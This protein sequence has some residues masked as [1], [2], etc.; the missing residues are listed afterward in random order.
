MPLSTS[1]SVAKTM[2]RRSYAPGVHGPKQVQKRLSTYGTKLREKQRAKLIYNLREKQFLNYY[3][4]AVT[5]QGDTSK[6]LMQM[7]EMRLENAVFRMGFAK[8]RQQARQLVSHKF[9]TVNGKPVNVRSYHVRPGDEVAFKSTKLNK[10][11]MPELMKNAESVKVPS[12]VAVDINRGAGKV[13]SVPDGDELQQPFDPKLII[14]FY[15][16]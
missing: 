12:W 16:R 4:S 6:I 5:K 1:S 14:E 10:K 7:L 11:L 13:L 9:F 2:Q 8:T 3:K 15:S